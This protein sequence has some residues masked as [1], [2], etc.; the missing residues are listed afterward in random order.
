MRAVG[1]APALGPTPRCR[2]QLSSTTFTFGGGR[3]AQGGDLDV[4]CAA[5]NSQA[6]L[7]SQTISESWNSPL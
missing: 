7:P 2:P 6:L 5:T 1:Q 3:Q 4:R